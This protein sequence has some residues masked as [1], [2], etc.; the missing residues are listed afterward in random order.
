VGTSTWTAAYLFRFYTGNAFGA[1]QEILLGQEVPPGESVDIPIQMTAPTTVG[2]YRSDW[3]MSNEVR[4][5]FK[6]PVY[7]E[8]TVGRPATSTPTANPTAT[9]EATAP[10]TP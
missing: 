6:D 1:P 8:I 4:S 3:V 7:L 5:N 2:E 9:T 10:A